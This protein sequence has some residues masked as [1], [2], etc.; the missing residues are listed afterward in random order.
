MGNETSANPV[1]RAGGRKARQA[2]RAAPLA[3]DIRPIRPGLVGGQYRPLKDAD[4]KRI[5]GAALAALQ[6]IG[7]ADAPPSG[8]DAMVA[9]GAEYGDDARLR[10][11]PTLVEDTIAK[12][13]RML[14]LHAQAP[15]HDMRLKDARVH[16][17]TAGAAVHCVDIE[18]RNYR[19]SQLQD[20][21]DAARIVEEMDNIHFYQRP[22]VARDMVDPTD[23]DLNTLYACLK[24]TTKHIGVSFTGVERA[25]KAFAMLHLVAGSEAAWR[26]RPF[27]SGSFTFVVPPMKFATE[28]CAVMETCIRGGMPVLLLSAGQAGATA[29]AAIAGAVVQAMAECLAGLIYVRAIKPGHPAIFGPWPFVSDLR[30]GAMSG[31]SGE[32]ALLSAA[33]GQM[34]RFYDLPTG[35]AAGMSDAKLPDIQCGYEKG[36]TNVLAGLAGTNLIYE[37]AGMH[38]SLLGFCLESLIID[39]DILGQAMR[40]VRGIE[41]DD[42]S[43][44]LAAIR[45]VCLEGPGHFLGHDQTLALMQ[46]D[47]VYPRIG[48]RLSPK[49]WAEVGKPDI[50]ARAVEEK[51]RIL[52]TRFPTHIDVALDDRI[53]DAFDIK[54]PRSAV[55]G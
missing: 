52:S 31:G 32:Q 20:L 55:Q 14:T 25:R 29:P 22:V 40:C 6:T 11:P 3:E 10:F 18:G 35:S 7:V 1:R 5:H 34:G 26:A 39:N 12:A 21:Y 30:T 27:V 8:V 28:A 48:D 16:F 33:C 46:R 24:G 43:L 53:R 13:P 19:E 15:H 54:L 42:D 9:L 41:V 4:M 37:S 50:V 2:L 17:G 44:S 38:G 47:Y 51:V 49:E 23:L 45:Q 36:I